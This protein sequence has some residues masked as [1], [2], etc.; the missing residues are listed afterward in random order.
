[1]RFKCTPFLMQTIFAAKTFLMQNIF[2][3]SSGGADSTLPG[4]A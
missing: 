2:N 1:M 4:R 3:A